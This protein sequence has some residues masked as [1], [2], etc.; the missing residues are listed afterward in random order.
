VEIVLFKASDGWLASFKKRHQ[1]AWNSVCGEAASVNQQTVE[2]WIVK[3]ASII[4]GYEPQNIF[5]GDET[6]LFLK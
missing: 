1:V 2:E 3:L 6:G 4:E 5:N